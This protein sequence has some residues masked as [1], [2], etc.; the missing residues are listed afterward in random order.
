MPLGRCR[1]EYFGV[2]FGCFLNMS[3]G[4]GH[5]GSVLSFLEWIKWRVTAMS[6]A[7]SLCFLDLSVARD[8]SSTR[9]LWSSLLDWVVGSCL[10]FGSI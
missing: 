3:F 6:T 8:R 2:V 10:P 9:R 7:L 4:E 5:L 1:M